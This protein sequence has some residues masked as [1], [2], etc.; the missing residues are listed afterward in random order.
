MT[1][2]LLVY[3]I[4]ETPLFTEQSRAIWTESEREDFCV[5]LSKNPLSGA[6]VSGSG[7]CRKVR[8]K[9]PGMG[10]RGG[11]R[12]IHYNQLDN[13]VIYLLVIYTKAER[14]SIPAHILKV[15]REMLA[16]G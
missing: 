5:W 1:Y 15:I 6:V 2:T 10:K 3:T 7:G 12:V 16:D 11:A 9:R 8:W 4:I 13:G 14:G